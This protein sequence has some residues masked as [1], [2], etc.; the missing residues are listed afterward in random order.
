MPACL[1]AAVASLAAT[2]A[3]FWAR[4]VWRLAFVRLVAVAREADVERA[5]VER[6]LVE[7]LARGNVTEVNVLLTS[8]AAALA[9]YQLVLIAVGYGKLRPRFLGA[10]PAATAQRG[11][12]GPVN[13]TVTQKGSPSALSGTRKTKSRVGRVVLVVVGA[14]VLLPVVVGVLLWRASLYMIHRVINRTLQRRLHIFLALFVTGGH[15]FNTCH[16]HT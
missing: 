13:T 2:L 8:V 5:E 12:S 4:V 11:T 9:V 14:L 10:G 7:R 6:E 3:S 16:S 1:A 15:F